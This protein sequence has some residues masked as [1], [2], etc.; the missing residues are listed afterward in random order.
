MIMHLSSTTKNWRSFTGTL[1]LAF[2]AM[3]GGCT[4]DSTTPGQP[5]L[6]AAFVGYSNA[7]TKQTTCGNCHISKQRTWVQT[8][9][10][11][12]W[13][14]LQN[15]GHAQDFCNSCHTT[16]GSS[17]LAPD[18]AGY[19]SVAADARKF[20]QDVQCES[21]HGPGA[22]HVT[23]PD[24][25]QPLST[26]VADTASAFGCATCH[27]GT[28]DPFVE[29]WRSSAHG[30]V[31]SAANG[32][33][34]CTGCH[35]AQGALARF[36]PGANYLEKTST[37]WQPITCAVCHD[38]HGSENS[39][40][41]RLPVGSPNLETNLCMQCHM[42]R[43]VP[44]PT[45]SR[46]PHSPQGPMVLGE[47]GYIPPNFQ[48]DATRAGTSHGT[49]ANPRLCATCH[50]EAFDVTD[51]ATGAFVLH[52]TGHNFKAVPCVDANGAPTN[53]ATCPDTQ[54]RFNA[55][56][57]GGCHSSTS[58]ASNL[59]LVLRGRLQAQIDIMWKDKNAN[60]ILD[61]LPTDSGLLALA[62]LT[63]P[64]DFSTATT[65]PTSGPC[66]GRPA[67]STVVT[68]GEGAW[69]NVDM[70]NRGDGSFGVHNP[71]FAEALL[72]GSNSALHVQYP[73]LPVPPARVQAET[74]A[75]MLELGMRPQPV[76]QR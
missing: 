66:L 47:A 10:A 69:F 30:T 31:Q 53:A 62:K 11:R 22:G 49:E 56:A 73:Y 55:C 4:S 37:T 28:H 29:Q 12:A 17:N 44:D 23:A 42:R 41:L 33:A 48:Y 34:S 65:A 2:L 68:V 15:S 39:H 18:S 20:Y 45:S 19:T 5:S 27:T 46:G 36:D 26:V 32:N 6:D 61:A 64:C 75:R 9:H 57:S 16:N 7:A 58:I 14:D 35:S 21:C 76:V 52:S 54:R 13:D 71:I 25:A 74:N 43:S 67:G 8:R 38:P 70:I 1:A 40:Q 59:R 3:L 51:L 60:G 72:L 50:M 24:D 63:S